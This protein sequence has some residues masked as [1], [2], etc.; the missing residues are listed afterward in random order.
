MLI[1]TMKNLKMKSNTEIE[2][3]K[4]TQAEHEDGIEKSNKP[5]RK[6][7]GKPSSRMYQAE[8]WILGLKDKVEDLDKLNKEEEKL[9]TQEKNL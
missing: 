4:Q 8:D 6:F 2:T 7:R 9:I 1:E 3:L 5:T